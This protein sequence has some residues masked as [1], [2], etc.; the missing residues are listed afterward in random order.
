ME[1]TKEIMF[2]DATS[3]I[4]RLYFVEVPRAMTFRELR[5]IMYFT[6]KQYGLSDIRSLLELM[7]SKGILRI[8][9]RSKN[10]QDI[11]KLDEDLKPKKEAGNE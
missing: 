7:E 9:T 4:I 2:V 10:C 5:L 3:D 6:S 8:L 1:Q 11:W